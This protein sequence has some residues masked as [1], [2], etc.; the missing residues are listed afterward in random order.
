LPWHKG[1]KSALSAEVEVEMKRLTTLLVMGI[2]MSTSVAD[3]GRIERACKASDRKAV[4]RALCS[5]VQRAADD[6]LNNSDQTLAVKFFKNPDLAQ[7][8]RQSDDPRKE[9]FWKRYKAFGAHAVEICR[10]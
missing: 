3:A 7:E 8:T 2:A 9:R 10:N 6:K 5:C 4:S 1:V